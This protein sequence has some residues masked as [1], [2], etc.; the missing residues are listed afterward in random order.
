MKNG[1]EKNK[2]GVE[3]E[4]KEKREKMAQYRRK[5][6]ND[7]HME[8]SKGGEKEEKW[9]KNKTTRHKILL[10]F[11]DVTQCG[12]VQLPQLLGR[13]PMHFLQSTSRHHCIKNHVSLHIVESPAQETPDVR[14]NSECTVY[15]SLYFFPQIWGKKNPN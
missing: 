9:L 12:L 15:E 13:F 3:I 7:R 8:R 11:W 2:Q 1:R 4:E 5:Q 6:N 10:S 14:H